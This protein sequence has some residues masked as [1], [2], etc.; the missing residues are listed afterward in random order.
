MY[1]QPTSFDPSWSIVRLQASDRPWSSVETLKHVPGQ[2]YLCAWEP[3]ASPP[4]FRVFLSAT[5]SNYE[6]I[7]AF[8]AFFFS[9]ISCFR[10]PVN[11]H[12]FRYQI[13]KVRSRC[14]TY[15]DI[16][17]NFYTFTSPL[18]IYSLT[19]YSVKRRKTLRF[20]NRTNRTSF[21]STQIL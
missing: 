1:R 10:S 21:F 8:N 18:A 19:R 3:N 5:N 7:I 2:C 12:I 17:P 14:Q 20:R 11:N 16:V 4:D 6:A 15:K 9:H 13:P